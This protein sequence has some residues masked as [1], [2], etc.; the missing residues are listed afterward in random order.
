MERKHPGCGGT[1]TPFDQDVARGQGY[2]YT[3]TDRLSAVLANRRY[4]AM[5]LGAAEFRDK[6]VLDMGSGDGTYT[7]ELA[8]QSGARAVLGVEPSV[9]GVTRARQ[10][11]QLPNLAFQAGFAGDLLAAGERF[12]LVVLRGVIHHMTDP[13]AE[14]AIGLQLA[15]TLVLLEPNGW[16]PLMKLVEK[17]SPYHREHEERSFRPGQVRGWLQRAGGRV[18]RIEY[19][20][21]VPYFCP[22]WLARSGQRLEPRVESWPALARFACGQYLL[23]AGR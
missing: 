11:Y 7:A 2:R 15:P 5:I 21:L 22:D 12:D 17:L 6:R 14:L 1:V 23:V 20:G 18:V 10:A 9:N 16:N 13:A 4:T 8:R 19:F 3:G